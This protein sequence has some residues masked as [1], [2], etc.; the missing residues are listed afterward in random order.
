MRVGRD[1]DEHPVPDY[2]VVCPLIEA[3]V[4]NDL[5]RN[6]KSTSKFLKEEGR[7]E[8]SVGEL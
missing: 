2:P 6:L 5:F 4:T 7:G 8:G 1:C 3:K